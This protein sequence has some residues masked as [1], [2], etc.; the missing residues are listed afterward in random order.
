MSFSYI[1]GTPV[2]TDI[3]TEIKKGESITIAGRTGVGKSTIFNLI[4][5]LL[6]P[7]EGRLLIG[8]FDAYLIPNE[9]KRAIFG[10]VEQS[11]RFI[12]GTVEQQISLGDPTISRR[13]VIDV[14][15]QVGLHESIEALSDGYDTLVSSDTSFSW[16][17]C[18]LLSIAR[19]VAAQ[20]PILLLDEIT[21]NLDSATEAMVMRALKSVSEGRTVISIS[22]RE[23]AMLECDR[24]IF[25]EN[26]KIAAQGSPQEV[27]KV[28]KSSELL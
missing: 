24:L 27:F 21:A 25:L 3:S 17:Q 16:G 15:R 14:C 6:T 22:H 1:S 2:L 26:G 12:P 9:E 8:G 10:Y 23:S 19:A 20:P 11:F 5:G 4:M 13:R 18:Q 7:T 28:V